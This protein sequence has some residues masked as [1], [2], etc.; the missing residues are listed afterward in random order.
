MLVSIGIWTA[1]DKVYISFVIGDN[2]FSAASY[3]LIGVGA[4]MIGICVVGICSLMKE[5]TKW[6]MIVSI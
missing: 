1:A 4:I 5:D 3:M 2:L 6:L